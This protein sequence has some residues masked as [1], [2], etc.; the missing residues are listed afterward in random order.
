MFNTMVEASAK[1]ALHDE[2]ARKEE[3]TKVWATARSCARKKE[4]L[5]SERDT[6][7]VGSEGPS[8]PIT[9]MIEKEDRSEGSIGGGKKPNG[10]EEGGRKPKK[11]KKRLT[12]RR[13]D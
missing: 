9:P 8:S 4:D 6:A 1:N 5:E 2:G 7:E 13:R 10:K 3:K 12:N 11:S